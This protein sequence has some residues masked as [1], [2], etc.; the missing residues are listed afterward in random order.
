MNE[1]PSFASD[2]TAPAHPAVIEWLARVNRG[3]APSY[4]DDRWTGQALGWLRDQFGPDSESI[5][6]WNGTGANVTALRA[7]TRPWHGILCHRLAHVNVDECGAP[8][9][10]TGC[11][12]IDLPGDHG[13][14]APDTIAA[15]ATGIG[16]EHHV[17]PR[18]VSITQSTEYGAVYTLAELSALS[19]A[20]HGLG[21][22]VHMD[23]ARLANAAASL[24]WPLRALTRDVGI[25]MVS[26]GF[27]KNGAVGVEAVVALDP[28]LAA[29]LRF[30][31]KQSTQLASKMRYLS[32]QVLALAED[33][34]WL[35]NAKHSN[36]MAARLAAGLR[37]IP[38]ITIT[39]PV[40]ANAVF[41]IMPPEMTS[42]LQRDFHFYVWNEGLGEVRLMTSWATTPESVDEFIGAAETA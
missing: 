31:R 27:T 23:G 9:L 22:L 29:E 37:G 1:R 26:F 19:A 16:V 30:I 17:Q 35:S 32:A 28:S 6:V 2:N 25:D 20:A 18:V 11:K 39:Q 10:L 15:A 41:A 38:G 12:L 7:L 42:R 33:D 34:L 5:L 8:E 24:G 40:D 13:K 14:L 36:A 21:M 4:G 3:S